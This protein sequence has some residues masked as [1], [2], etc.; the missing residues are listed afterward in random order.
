MPSEPGMKD[1]SFRSGANE[2]VATP[3][4]NNLTV[5]PGVDVTTSLSVPRREFLV[6]LAALGASALVSG[7]SS[8][9]QAP[10]AVAAKPHRIDVHYHFS[11]PGFIA[12]IT[13]RKTGQRPLMEWTPA[14]AIEAMDKGGVATSMASISEPGVWF[15]DNAAARS[16]ARESNEYG[17]RLMADYPG[18]F[19]LFAILP[20]P[21]IDGSLREIEYSF[22]TL[23]ADGACFM[24]SYQGKYL[25]DPA[26]APV[27]DELNRRKAVVYTHPFRAECCIN[28]LPDNDGL[29]ITLTTDTTYTI[30]SVLFSG[31]AAR[32]PDIRFIWSHGGG[33]MPYITGR[34]SGGNRPDMAQKLPKGVLYEIQ[35]F[36]YD[37]AQAV[38][39][40]TLAALTKLVPASHILFGTDYPFATAETDAK[41]LTDFGLS[42]GDLRA[43][44]RDNA[45]QLFP[46]LNT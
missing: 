2:V 19:G 39:P 43:I 7:I 8:A 10:V 35:K 9:A 20:M 23:K 46:R 34:F 4:E 29:G 41:G 26:F 5:R 17:A 1:G 37:T 45:L 27:M 12:A 14:K 32:C 38:S 21:D 24:T 3:I 16:L 31:T 13:A 6:G 28:L 30:A 36:Y 44:E 11:S 15:G 22:D 42:A 25:G 33:T 18:R 40:Y